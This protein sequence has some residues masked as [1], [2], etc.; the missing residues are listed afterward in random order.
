MTLT[1]EEIL[2]I[3]RILHVTAYGPYPENEKRIALDGIKIL[4]AFDELR[5]RDER[6]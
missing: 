4:Y 3:R 6:T 2:R 1:D 5:A